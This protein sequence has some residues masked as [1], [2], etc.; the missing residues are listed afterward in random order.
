MIPGHYQTWATHVTATL[1]AQGL[2]TLTDEQ[3][4][5]LTD[6]DTNDFIAKQAWFYSVLMDIVKM[7]SGAAI[8]RQHE[9]TFDA[10]QVLH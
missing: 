3:Y 2:G 7:P 9:H 5:P 10:R 8:V 4:V 1:R 6:A